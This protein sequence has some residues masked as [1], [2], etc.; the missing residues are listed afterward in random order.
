MRCPWFHRLVCAV[1][2]TTQAGEKMY[3]R[4]FFKFQVRKFQLVI[5]LLYF[6]VH[7]DIKDA[8]QSERLYVHVQLL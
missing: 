5:L 6:K 1:S 4:K 7:K 3:F 8:Q 2:Y